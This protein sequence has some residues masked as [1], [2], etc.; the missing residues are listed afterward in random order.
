MRVLRVDLVLYA[1]LVIYFWLIG[2]ELWML[3][4]SGGDL[5]VL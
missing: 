5:S 2:Y 4:H 3:Q 1:V